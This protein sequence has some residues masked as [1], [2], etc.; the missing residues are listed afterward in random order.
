ML[1]LKFTNCTCLYVKFMWHINFGLIHMSHI[2]PL[3]ASFEWN[4][5]Q[6]SLFFNIKIASTV[7]SELSGASKKD[8]TP[9]DCLYS[10]WHMSSYFFPLADLSLNFMC[11][12][13]FLVH[14]TRMEH[15]PNHLFFLGGLYSEIS[16][17]S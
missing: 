15:S 8:N 10:M 7:T 14:N 6:R 1:V 11:E 17:S 13:N 9:H 5:S 3:P 2:N 4:T 16:W 12:I